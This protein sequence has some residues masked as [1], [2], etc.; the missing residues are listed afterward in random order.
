MKKKKVVN[1][2]NV[3][4]DNITNSEEYVSFYKRFMAFMASVTMCLYSSYYINKDY[5]EKH[6]YYI[7]EDLL[8]RG[9]VSLNVIKDKIYSSKYLS[10]EEK[11]FLYNEQL[12][13]DNGLGHIKYDKD[14]I[15][16]TENILHV[17]DILYGKKYEIKKSRLKT[18]FK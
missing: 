14:D 17:V 12:F 8:F 3:S 13:D 16:P 4:R 6:H 9:S 11:D 2:N 1:E 7:L 15:K 10:D 5:K 18:I